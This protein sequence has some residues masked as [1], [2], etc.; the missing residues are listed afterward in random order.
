MLSSDFPIFRMTN[1]VVIQDLKQESD[2]MQDNLRRWKLR[3]TRSEEA[4]AL[5]VVEPEE[6]EVVKGQVS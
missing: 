2:E 1:H 4:P 6:L 5:V 3:A